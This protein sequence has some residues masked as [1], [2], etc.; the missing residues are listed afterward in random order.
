LVTLGAA[1]GLVR[2]VKVGETSCDY[3]V[4]NTARQALFL[5]TT[6]EVKYKAK[7]A[8]DTFFVSIGDFSS[9][10]LVFIGTQLVKWNVEQFALIN[11]VLVVAWVATVIGILRQQR[12]MTALGE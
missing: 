4:Q 3:S 10:I 5:P 1:I 12:R 8:I 11:F 7:A 9:A 6:R 2:I